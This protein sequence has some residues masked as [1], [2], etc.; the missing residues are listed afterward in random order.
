[1]A[2]AAIRNQRWIRWLS[3]LG[4]LLILK[5]TWQ[6]LAIYSDYFPVNLNSEFWVLRQADYRGLNKFAFYI[7][8]IASP[9]Q[10]PGESS[11]SASA[12]DC[13]S[14]LRRSDALGIG[15]QCDRDGLLCMGW[16]TFH[17]RLFGEFSSCGLVYGL[18]MALCRTQRVFRTSALDVAVV[19][20]HL[21]C[22]NPTGTRRA[23][24]A[25]TTRTDDEL[26]ILSLVE[27]DRATVRPRMLF[28]VVWKNRSGNDQRYR[29]MKGATIRSFW[30]SFRFSFE[31]SLSRA[32]RRNNSPRSTRSEPRTNER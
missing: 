30:N 27:L 21:F 23:F 14:M 19:C 7:H 3:W 31:A 4:A 18:G 1:M 13:W 11:L 9:A 22:G 17:G 8:I 12:S 2:Q 24:R 26:P 20:C 5:V 6:V 32:S 28:P 10:P 15:S 16:A 25:V 29:L